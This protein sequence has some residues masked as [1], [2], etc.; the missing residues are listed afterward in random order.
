MRDAT[1]KLKFKGAMRVPHIFTLINSS[2][3]VQQLF[4][5]RE[6]LPVPTSQRARE[7]ISLNSGSIPAGGR[8]VVPP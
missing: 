7:N 1:L 2:K 3:Q 5:G 6:I 4:F 8:G